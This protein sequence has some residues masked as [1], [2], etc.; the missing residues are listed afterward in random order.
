MKH[1]DSN[2]EKVDVI[3]LAGGLGTRLREV[4][5]DLQ[6]RLLLSKIGRFLI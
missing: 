4:I 1:N 5:N 2:N 6:N 3:I